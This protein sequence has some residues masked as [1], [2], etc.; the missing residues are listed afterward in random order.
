M[1]L[2]L[3]RGRLV[4]K[5]DP[6]EPKRGPGRPSKSASPRVTR[7]RILEAA[8]R[9][10]DEHGMESVGIR[11]LA[12]E[13]GVAPNSLYS[14]VRDKNDVI[15]GAVELAFGHL[16]IPEA[17]GGTW[18]ERVSELC[19]WL[20]SRLLEHPRLVATPRFAEGAPFPFIAFPATV[21]LV[22][23]EAGF[24]GEELIETVYAVFYHTV[25]FVTM[26]VSRAQ[27]G[28]PTET[29]EFLVKQLDPEKFDAAM[30]ERAAQ[31]VPLI[32]GLDLDAVFERSLRG[33][34][35]GLPSPDATRRRKAGT[36]AKH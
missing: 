30:Q 24:E 16:E 10:I 7:A 25:G 26:E 29:D 4:P 27:H 23:H 32:R 36:R 31:M 17:S 35:D 3:E 11:Q 15:H 28:V 18:K 9:R 1:K 13:L 19:T 22:L 6:P 33:M 12:T 34:L 8:L 2:E 5:T 14:Y 20:R 21:G